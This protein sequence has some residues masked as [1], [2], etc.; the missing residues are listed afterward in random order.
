M[1]LRRS[2]V[3][4]Y[5]GRKNVLVLY[6]KLL[7][8]HS[9]FGLELVTPPKRR[10]RLSAGAGRVALGNDIPAV[11]S[12]NMTSLQVTYWENV[13]S[14]DTHVES[15]ISPLYDI[16]P[17]RLRSVYGSCRPHTTTSSG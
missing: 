4:V 14:S 13:V 5:V 12:N 10:V 2:L 8:H 7:Y 17:R 9:G 6:T 3:A 11:F 15:T 16:L 1:R